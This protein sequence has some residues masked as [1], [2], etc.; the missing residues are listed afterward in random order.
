M[1]W[2]LRRKICRAMLPPAMFAVISWCAA[3]PATNAWIVVTR[4]VAVKQAIRTTLDVRTWSRHWRGFGRTKPIKKVNASWFIPGCFFAACETLSFLL[5]ALAFLCIPLRE[6][7][8]KFHA[9]EQREQSRKGLTK[10]IFTFPNFLIWYV[11]TFISLFSSL[12]SINNY[13]LSSKTFNFPSCILPLH[14]DMIVWD[15]TAAAK[16]DFYYQR[17]H[18]AFGTTSDR[19]MITRR[20]S[21]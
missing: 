10:A 12:T 5:C 7:A 18:W 13:Y 9:K 14:P 1:Q 16:A 19:W 15:I 4:A 8:V 6:I 17:Y 2:M 3:V 11:Q 21:R 20:W